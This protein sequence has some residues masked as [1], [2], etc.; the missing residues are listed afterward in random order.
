MDP[1]TWVERLPP[2]EC[3]RRLRS[4]PVGRIGVLVDGVPEVYPVNFRVD[5][6]SLVFC[7]DHGSKLRGLERSPSVCFEVDGF[8]VTLREGWSVMVKGCA[9]VVSGAE[10]VQRLSAEPF[11]FW[12][13]GPKAHWVRVSAEQVSGRHLHP[14]GSR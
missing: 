8:D 1:R 9:S 11:E 4:T 7:T 10:E 14:P 12:E 5:G 13:L 2:A 3:W 6:E